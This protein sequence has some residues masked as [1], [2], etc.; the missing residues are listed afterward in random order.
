MYQVHNP[1][2]PFFDTSVQD[3]C[4]RFHIH[5]RTFSLGQ[6]YRFTYYA[7]VLFN[8]LCSFL[9]SIAKF[10]CPPLSDNTMTTYSLTGMQE[11]ATHSANLGDQRSLHETLMETRWN[12]P[13]CS[14]LLRDTF[15]TRTEQHYGCKNIQ[16]QCTRP[17][18]RSCC[19]DTKTCLG[20]LCFV[21]CTHES[22]K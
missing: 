2:H 16:Y 14:S 15:P 4:P 22:S 12:S 11:S 10:L 6:H 19:L 1:H 13:K 20:V 9:I 8:L 7:L 5:I 18:R 3:S 21:P 17:C